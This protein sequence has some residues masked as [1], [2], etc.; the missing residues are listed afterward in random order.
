[1]R[2]RRVT[3]GVGC[4]NSWQIV[5]LRAP[6][7]R[8][9]EAV[10]TTQHTGANTMATK[11]VTPKMI[12]HWIGSDHQNTAEYLQLLTEIINGEYSPEEFKQDVID[13]WGDE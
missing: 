11:N 2:E 7:I 8:V 4:P 6:C 13:L 9:L 3:S 10:L 12:A 1:M 5:M